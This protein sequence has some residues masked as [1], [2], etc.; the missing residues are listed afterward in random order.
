MSTMTVLS[1][2]ISYDISAK[3]DSK[4]IDGL[5]AEPEEEG[6]KGEGEAGPPVNA[7]EGEPEREKSGRNI[8]KPR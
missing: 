8:V 1:V 2:R 4:R 7:T 3:D 5:E 6:T